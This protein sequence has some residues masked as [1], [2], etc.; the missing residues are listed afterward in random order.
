MLGMGLC[1]A[2]QG[3]ED[4]LMI[5]GQWRMAGHDFANSRSQL[6]CAHFLS[7]AGIPARNRE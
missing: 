6:S 4:D 3:S 7:R 2:A 5:R 1:A